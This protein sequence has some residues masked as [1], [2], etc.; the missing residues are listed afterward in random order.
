MTDPVEAEAADNQQQSQVLADDVPNFA[1]DFSTDTREMPQLSRSQKRWQHTVSIQQPALDISSEELQT[2]QETDP[3][4]QDITAAV[5]GRS[6]TAGVGLL[7]HRWVPLKRNPESMFIDQLVLAKMCRGT[8]LKV[9]DIPLAGHLG[10]EKTARRILQRFYW[11]TL[12]LEFYRTCDLC[13][14]T[15][16]YKQ[17]KVPLEENRHGYCGATTK[18]SLWKQIHIGGM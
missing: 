9:Q 6:S 10:H 18:E 8:V 4:L 13:Q 2:L 5:E 7:Y 12:Y 16:R 1:D 11:P 15:S 14:K 3:T 17:P